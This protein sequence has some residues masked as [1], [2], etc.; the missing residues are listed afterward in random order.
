MRWTEQM[1]KAIVQLRAIYLL[2]EFDAHWQFHI[3][4]DQSRLYPVW[5]VVPN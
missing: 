5:T 2:G 4:Q 1:A 3:E